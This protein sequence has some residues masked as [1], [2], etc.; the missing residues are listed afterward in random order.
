MSKPEVSVII[1]AYNCAGYI[2]K[3]IDSVLDQDV[4]LEII[5]IDDCSTDN[6]DEVMEK[7]RD[8]PALF[9]VKNSK[10][11]GVAQ[12]RNR[13]VGLARGNYIAFLDAD[14]YWEKDKLKKQLEAITRTGTVLCCTA[15]EIVRMDGS[16]TGL[17]FPVKEHITYGELLKQNSINCSSVLLETAV[18]R[19]FPMEH[20][21]S[22]EDYIMWLKVLSRYGEACGINEPLLKYRMSNKSKSGSKLKSAKMTMK[23]YR[24]MNFGMGKSLLCFLSYT[25]HGIRKYY[26]GKKRK[27]HKHGKDIDSCGSGL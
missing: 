5:V 25:L 11:L 27:V 9:Y 2:S 20:E 19:E 21:D 14:D 4:E 10:N 12:S 18:A 24:Y 16:R 23:V 3:A 22:H 7:Y 26:F 17:I 13:G 6:L 15:R 8:N 1:P